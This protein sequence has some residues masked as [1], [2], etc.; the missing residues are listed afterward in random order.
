MLLHSSSTV[1]SP[2]FEPKTQEA[3]LALELAT[4]LSDTDNFACYMDLAKR[5]NEA[6]L[7]R[8]LCVVQKTDEKYIKRSRGALFVYLVKNFKQP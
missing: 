1:L 5:Y 6:H 8:M 3:H 2:D 4:K 7:R